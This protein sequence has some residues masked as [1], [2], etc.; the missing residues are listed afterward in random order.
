MPAILIWLSLTAANATGGEVYTGMDFYDRW[1]GLPDKQ[2]MQMGNGFMARPGFTDSAMV[3]YSIVA[4]RLLSGSSNDNE[5]QICVKALNACGYLY[6]TYYFDYEKAYSFF[7]QAQEEAERMGMTAF[8]P[9]IY[10]N[11]ANLMLTNSEL[12]KT[13]DSDTRISDMYKK[14]FQAACDAEKWNLMLITIFNMLNHAIDKDNT[15]TLKAER[16]KFKSLQLPDS[17]PMLQFTRLFCN[18][19][20]AF[21]RHDYMSAYNLFNDA[22]KCINTSQTPERYMLCVCSCKAFM[23]SKM[24][25]YAEAVSEMQKTERI[26]IENNSRDVLVDVYDELATYCL[27]AGDTMRAHTYRY[28]YYEKK[29]SIMSVNKLDNVNKLEFIHQ[30]RTIDAQV[31]QLSQKQHMQRLMLIGACTVAVIVGLLT[32]MLLQKNR[33]LRE[34]NRQFYEKS[35]Q[36]LAAEEERRMER[37]KKYQGSALDEQMKLELADRIGSVLEQPDEVCSPDFSMNRL[38]ELLGV[39]YKYVSQVINEKYGKN[40]NQLVTEQRINEAC[41]RINDVETYGLYTIEAIAN[42]VGFKSRPNFVQNFKRIVGL[43]PS[44]YQRIAR[45]KHR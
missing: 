27:L 39:N 33:R 32:L 2:L 45:N 19:T 43:T 15:N 7:V 6:Y 30:L 11:Q 9:H 17:L 10:L 13:A 14:T 12:H 4:N 44:E 18:A 40:F 38:V 1:I 41:R 20:D 25:R 36:A 28:L 35:L 42:D 23:M 22:A 21:E 37:R 3:C 5:R 31:Q 29:D 16:Q 24:G 8:L 26:A 34:N